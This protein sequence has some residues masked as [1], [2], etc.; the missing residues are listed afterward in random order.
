MN[1]DDL[2]ELDTW[3][4]VGAEH[5]LAAAIEAS[6]CG[7]DFKQRKAELAKHL[8]Y[9]KPHVIDHWFNHLIIIP[10][11]HLPA[12][13][14]FTGIH[15]SSL[16]TYW[17]ATYTADDDETGEISKA[18]TPRITDGEFWIVETARAVFGGEADDRLDP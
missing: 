2:N 9:S 6:L 14:R 8:G 1:T 5:R 11:R 18:I 15:L 4:G 17:L 16:V 13:A 10:I 12:I 3:S 7:E